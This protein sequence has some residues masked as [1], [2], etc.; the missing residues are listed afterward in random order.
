MSENVSQHF[1]LDEVIETSTG[2]AN[3][4]P[5]TLEANAKRLAEEVLEPLRVHLG[6][7]RVNSWY[8]SLAVNAAVGGEAKSAHLEARAADVVP[9]GDVFKAF[10][11][12]LL[13][14]HE[15]P[16]DRI[17]YEKRH[18]EWLHIQVARDG[19]EPKHLAF[20]SSPDANGKM[21]YVRYEV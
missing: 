5:M 11:T 10:K 14:L 17:I 7:L 6:P 1:S 15:L 3:E 21:V 13:F 12:A 8:R 4:I 20:V 18:S 19:E 16:I 9:N 2:L